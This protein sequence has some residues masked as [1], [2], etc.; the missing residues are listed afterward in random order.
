[1]VASATSPVG[2][3]TNAAVGAK[4]AVQLKSTRVAQSRSPP[5]LL[6][7]NPTLQSAQLL[8]GA[9]LDEELLDDELADDEELLDDAPPDDAEELVDEALLDAPPAPPPP[10][11][12][13]PPVP[14][15]S[16]EE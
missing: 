14:A 6:G 11:A 7:S 4:S 10:V 15:L 8:T 3:A 12:D 16:T 9:P 1:M 5:F 2:P 13:E